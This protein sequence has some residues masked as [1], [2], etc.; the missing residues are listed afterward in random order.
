MNEIGKAILQKF[1]QGHLGF[2][3]ME[4]MSASVS[5]DPLAYSDE[6]V[7]GVFTA[8]ALFESPV[9]LERRVRNQGSE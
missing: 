1:E 8:Y 6:E 4:I 3:D 7:D 5:V 9:I 2:V